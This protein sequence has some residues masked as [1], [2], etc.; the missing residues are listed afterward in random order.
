MYNQRPPTP[1]TPD[2]E[3][4][5]HI[6]TSA[7]HLMAYNAPRSARKDAEQCFLYGNF[8]NKVELSN[9]NFDDTGKEMGVSYIG[10]RIVNG[11]VRL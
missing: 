2:E 7:T 3:G 6:S 8:L 4:G 9:K 5:T 11:F 1:S 10:C